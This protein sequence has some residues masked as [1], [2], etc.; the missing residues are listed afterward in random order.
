MRFNATT[1]LSAW[2]ISASSV[3]AQAAPQFTARPAPEH[4]YDGGWEHFVGGGLASL[5][6][7]GDAFPDLVAAGGSNPAQLLVNTTTGPGAPLQ[8]ESQTPDALSQVGLT[9]VYPLD[10]DGDSQLDL[11]LL[12]VGPDQI[13]RGLGNCQFEPMTNIGFDSADHWTTAF[14]A[15]WEP[16]QSLPTLAFGTYVDRNDPT[17]PFESCDA[18]LLYRP[19]GE[20][21]QALLRPWRA[22]TDVGDDDA[23]ASLPARRRL[24]FLPPVGHGHCLTRYERRRLFRRL[25]DIDGRSEVSAV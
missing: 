24:G 25:P 2:A 6:C 7:N 5:D 23:A 12:R 14:S 22:G 3:F 10:I 17:G 21:R 11:V 8:F 20:Q 16:G 15:T 19:E 4:I 13:L 18:T 9:G 1:W